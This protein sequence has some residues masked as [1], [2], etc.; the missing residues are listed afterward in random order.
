[1]ILLFLLDGLISVAY[2]MHMIVI[3]LYL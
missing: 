3:W 1:V 2:E